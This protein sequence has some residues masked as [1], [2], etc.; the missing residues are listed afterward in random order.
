MKNVVK[1]VCCLVSFV[2]LADDV[3]YFK[4]TCPDG[5]KLDEKSGHQFA[6]VDEQTDKQKLDCNSGYNLV[7]NYVEADK[8]KMEVKKD[9]ECSSGYTLKIDLVGKDSCV[10]ETSQNATCSSGY[11][12]KVKSIA[13]DKCQKVD[14]HVETPKCDLKFGEFQNNW[15]IVHS[16]GNDYCAHES[17][18]SKGIRA[19]K[20]DHHD[21]AVQ[22]DYTGS[23][24]KCVNE[25]ELIEHD[26]TCP[27]GYDQKVSGTDTCVN[28][29]TRAP[30]CDSGYDYTSLA[31]EDACKKDDSYVPSCPSG[32]Y[33][34]KVAGAD[35]CVMSTTEDHRPIL[36]KM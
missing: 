18:S 16:S 35:R 6:C 34:K 36:E 13:K 28:K 11:T 20:C 31:G 2:A 33:V 32:G 9:V 19:L 10:K 25:S 27:S 8:C 4:V 17:S 7:T 21:Y 5:F 24:D 22:V 1:I 3:R 30:A 26:I 12:Q 15:N 23:T 14:V 29:S